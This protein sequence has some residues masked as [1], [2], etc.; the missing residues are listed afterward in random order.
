TGPDGQMYAVQK[1][2]F[3]WKKF[4]IGLGVPLF[5]M[6]VPLILMMIV[7]SMDP[8]NDDMREST[9]IDMERGDGTS[10]TA[11]YSMSADRLL[12]HC[13]VKEN[14]GQNEW[15]ECE[16]DES[17]LT[18]YV[19]TDHEI[20]LVL[21]NGTAYSANL[22]LDENGSVN[23]CDLP[24]WLS[25]DAW[26]EC[27]TQSDG[28]FII[29]KETWNNGYDNREQVGHWNASEGVVHFD[30][31]EDHD[32][33]FEMEYSIRETVGG[34]TQEA[35]VIHY[36]DGGDHG[37]TFDLTVETYDR[38]AMDE[39]NDNYATMEA[40]QVISTLMCMAAPLAAIGMIIY[41]FAASGG[42]AMGIGATVAIVSYPVIGFFG[43]II[44]LSGGF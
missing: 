13:W 22:T 28:G 9:N 7:E 34:W 29:I 44:A 24:Y 33:E 31:G 39:V 15:Y 38:E 19:V 16:S 6:L 40:L 1:E 27:R 25:E 17:S 2:P 32:S 37:T 21:V 35:G 5:L 23:W 18:L 14:E 8:W 20:D 41:G 36:D 4:Y 11:N 26:Y 30:D 42:K 12:E 3:V 43:C 10:Y